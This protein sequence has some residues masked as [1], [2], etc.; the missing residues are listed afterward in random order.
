MINAMMPPVPTPRDLE[1]VLALVQ[2]VSD[3]KATQARIADLTAA[4]K[5]AGDQIAEAQTQAAAVAELR[6]KTESSLSEKQRAADAKIAADRE[7]YD[8][9]CR[10]RTDDLDAREKRV[11]EIEAK[12]EADAVD[13]ARIKADIERR[14]KLVTAA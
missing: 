14:F 8:D 5:I 13:A 6:R 2:L 3:P 9:T 1:A 7:A 12:A 11:A 10:R 4:A